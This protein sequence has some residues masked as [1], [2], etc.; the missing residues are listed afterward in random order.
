MIGIAVGFLGHIRRV[1]QIVMSG[2]VRVDPEG[3]LTISIFSL[4]VFYYVI[5]LFLHVFHQ[6]TRHQRR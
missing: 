1:I 2:N 4:F 6:W 3:S 5:Y